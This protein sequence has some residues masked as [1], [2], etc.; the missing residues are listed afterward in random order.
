M[1]LRSL[2]CVIFGLLPIGC[3]SVEPE[4]PSFRT[5]TTIVYH[6]GDASIPPPYQRNYTISMNRSEIRLVVDSYGDVI[7]D[8]RTDIS[9]DQFD[10]V[11]KTIESA[12]IAKR[13]P[14]KIGDNCTGGTSDSLKIV[15]G[16]AILLDGNL[17][18]CGEIEYGDLEG[19]I[20]AVKTRLLSL[21]PHTVEISKCKSDH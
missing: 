8:S 20:C 14:N 1:K 4:R 13:S 9:S 3:R 16:E 15:N 2:I 5:A 12:G 21:L 11:L 18:R 10:E 6:F 19:D 17:T 7:S